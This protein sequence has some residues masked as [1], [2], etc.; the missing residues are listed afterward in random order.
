MQVL[1]QQLRNR[2][3]PLRSFPHIGDVRVIGGV[4]VLEMVRGPLLYAA[5]PDY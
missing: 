2:L 5:L 3:E 4:G 1:E